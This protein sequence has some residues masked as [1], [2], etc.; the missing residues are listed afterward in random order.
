MLTRRE[1]LMLAAAPFVAPR[2]IDAAARAFDG[3]PAGKPMRGAFMIL[4]TPFSTSG[5]VD[6]DDLVRE[7]D[8]C[9]RCGVHG[10]V[11]PQGSS[12]VRFLTRDERMRGL[13]V[14]AKAARGKKPAL[15]LGVQGRD[16]AEMLEYAHAAEALAPDALIA[17]PP[18]TAG[19]LDEYASYFRAL[20]GVTRRP[21]IVQTSGGAPSL[22]PS[23]DLIVSL[24]REFPHLGYVKE[25]SQPLVARMKE[26][27]RQRPPMK[28]VFG[29]NLGANWLYEMRLGLDG[30][31]TGN[32]MYADAMARMW[33]LHE[34][35]EAEPLRDL[36][37]KFLL[38]RN[39]ADSIP[40]VDLYVMKKR[41]IF[42][43]AVQRSEHG[44]RVVEFSH[45]EIAEI[46]YRF[47]ALKPYLTGTT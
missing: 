36:F 40:G 5:G 44:P 8:F 18:T 46:E 24:A 45:D 42:K 32:A 27:L 37:S 17:M 10:L 3:G 15:V 22:P 29:A 38:M 2:A 9:D 28:A 12:G 39:L 43:A 7:V 35:G 47:A 14:L 26:E 30:V 34:H 31:I 13:E 23:V 33:A 1:C 20:A 25:E 4:T 11:W 6:W 41:G 19:S 21:V 16:T